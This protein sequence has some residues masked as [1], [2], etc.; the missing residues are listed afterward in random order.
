MCAY[1]G[2]QVSTGTCR[3]GGTYKE[4]LLQ[5]LSDCRSINT[6]SRWDRFTPGLRPVR[7]FGMWSSAAQHG[8][9][10]GLLPRHHTPAS[11]TILVVGNTRA[12][13][14]KDNRLYGLVEGYSFVAN[15]L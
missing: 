7:D 4:T 13:H 12:H 3:A 14:R 9:S 1:H 11:S 8:R 10:Q 15:P 6:P 2:L 5:T